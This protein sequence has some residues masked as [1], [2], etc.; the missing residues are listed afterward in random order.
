MDVMTQCTLQRGDTTMVAWIPSQF[1]VAGEYVK[2]RTRGRW[3]DGWLVKAAHATKTT[4]DVRSLHSDHRAF[5]Y[6]EA[7]NR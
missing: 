3:V 7:K 6:Y 1:A 5:R 4:D 2:I